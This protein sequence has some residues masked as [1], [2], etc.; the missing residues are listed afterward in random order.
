MDWDGVFQLI[1]WKSPSVAYASES[2]R[3]VVVIV[4]VGQGPKLINSSSRGAAKGAHCTGKL[5]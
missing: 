4:L 5:D 3:R 2:Q 1:S